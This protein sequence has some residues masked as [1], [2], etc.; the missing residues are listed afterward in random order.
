[1]DQF[2]ILVIIPVYNG[3]K[4]LKETINSIKNQ[5]GVNLKI[6]IIDDCSTDNSYNIAKTFSGITVLRNTKNMGNYYSC[7]KVLYLK[8]SDP[9]WTHFT[10]HG[11]DDVS[12]S[13]RL[14][15]QLSSF[16]DKTIAVGCRFVRMNYYTR[17]KISVNPKTNESQLLFS[18]EVL[19]IIGYRDN[20]RAGCDTEYKRRLELARPN[21][22][23]SL[24][25]ILMTAYLHDDNL[26]KKI[27]IGGKY[28]RDYVNQFTRKHLEMKK[29]NNYYQAF[30]L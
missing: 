18:R 6:I 27:P 12:N 13:N 15:K 29:K 25:E 22:I 28:R 20:G 23:K 5:V 17:Q 2:K 7:N 21:S 24:D 16:N 14:F 10:F 19:N 30:T 1:M 3:S 9:E 4:F 26:T 11:A 8:Q